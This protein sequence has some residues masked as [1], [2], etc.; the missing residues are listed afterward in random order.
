MGALQQYTCVR[1][2]KVVPMNLEF[3]GG[4]VLSQNAIGLRVNANVKDSWG[5]LQAVKTLPKETHSLCER[6]SMF[7]DCL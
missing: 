3:L 2:A 7:C 1:N 6:M 5:N 4:T